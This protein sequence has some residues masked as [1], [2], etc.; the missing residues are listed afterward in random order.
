MTGVDTPS[1]QYTS[2]ATLEIEREPL[3]LGLLNESVEGSERSTV[4]RREEHFGSINEE[5]KN[6]SEGCND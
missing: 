6:Q 2:E 4:V 1:I 3:R 5:M